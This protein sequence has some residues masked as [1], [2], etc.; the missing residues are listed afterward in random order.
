MADDMN[1][2]TPSGVAAAASFILTQLI[3]PLIDHPEQ[4]S[5]DLVQHGDSATLVNQFAPEDMEKSVGINLRT[6]RLLQVIASAARMRAR[7]RFSLPFRLK[8]RNARSR[9]DS[10]SQAA[11]T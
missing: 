6:G 11:G 2:E 10:L 1:T 4:C 9:S 8:S 3:H 5:L 7:R